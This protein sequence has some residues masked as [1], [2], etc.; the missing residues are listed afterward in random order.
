M[1]IGISFASLL[2]FAFG[3]RTQP[4]DGRPGISSGWLVPWIPTTPPP[5]QSVSLS[6]YADVPNAQG[7]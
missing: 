4:C 2:I 3:T 6:E 1:P 7:P 5:G